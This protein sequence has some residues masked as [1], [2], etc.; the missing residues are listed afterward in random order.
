MLSEAFRILD[1][2][3]NGQ[4]TDAA[5]PVDDTFYAVGSAL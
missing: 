2:A 5:M 3:E 1:R 4:D